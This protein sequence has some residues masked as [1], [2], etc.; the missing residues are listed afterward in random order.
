MKPITMRP[1]IAIP[2][3]P[4]PDSAPTAADSEPDSGIRAAVVRDRKPVLAIEL[5]DDDL[6]EEPAFHA[7][8]PPASAPPASASPAPAPPAPAPPPSA[9]PARP[10]FESAAAADPT[11][12]LFDLLSELE[13]VA[14]ATNA[15]TVCAEALARALA[16][17][18]VLVHMHDAEDGALR[19]I[20][21]HGPQTTALVHTT[22]VVDDDLVASPV[23][24]NAK[25]VTMTFDG[26]LPRSAPRRLR[27]VGV[28]RN[29][30]AVP[31][32]VW[33]RFVAMIEVIDP[34][35]HLAPRA[36]D[37]ASYVAKRLAEY[38]ADRAAA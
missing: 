16:A 25:A 21:A 38:L 4:P 35:E 28:D 24:M 20:G 33:N 27:V 3:P 19:V 15:A 23:S 1:A 12:L 11:D 30:V 10:R 29:V 36:A 8:P 37:A 22:E 9:S 34:G 14:T 2:L 26:E 6:V 31:A 18:A 32:M 17:R 7:M 5:G 13:L